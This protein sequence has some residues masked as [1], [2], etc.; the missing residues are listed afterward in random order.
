M[1][2][3]NEMPLNVV[4]VILADTLEVAGMVRVVVVTGAS[5]VADGSGTPENPY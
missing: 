1:L 5:V 3:I 4:H 2:P